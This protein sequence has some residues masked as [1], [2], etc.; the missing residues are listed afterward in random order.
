[1]VVR[2]GEVSHLLPVGMLDWI[3]GRGD[4]LS[5]SLLGLHIFILY[6]APTN[7]VADS[8]SITSCL[9]LYVINA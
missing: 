4:C 5:H 6:G 9:T 8:V 1:M 2:W 7:I 3:V